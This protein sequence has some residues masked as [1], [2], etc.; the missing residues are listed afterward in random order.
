M[1]ECLKADKPA[2]AKPAEA[3]PAEPKPAAAPAKK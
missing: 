2:E 3:V 1:S